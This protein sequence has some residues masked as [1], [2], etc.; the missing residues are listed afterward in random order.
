MTKRVLDVV[1][2]AIALFLAAPLV[3]VLAGWIKVHD[4]GSPWFVQE[5]VGRH[6]R[7]F[8]LFKLRTMRPGPHLPAPTGKH[9]DK[10]APDPRI[11]RPGRWLRRLSLDELPQLLNVVRGEMSL[12]GPRPPL[13]EEVARYEPHELRR[14]S[15][16]PGMTGLWQVSGRADLPWERWV[17]LDLQY[18]DQWSLWL[19]LTLL[20]RTV[21]AVIR[22]T[23]A[24]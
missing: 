24:R 12:V 22:G 9:A 4:Q 7:R 14:L 16:P 11:T 19:D 10:H 13:P 1:V 15:V 8:R 18:V 6:G 2:A 5:R 20:A 23:G 21:P 3:L 17:A